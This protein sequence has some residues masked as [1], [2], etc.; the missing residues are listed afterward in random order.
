LKGASIHQ[1]I[2]SREEREGLRGIL[3]DEA[4]TILERE[5]NTPNVKGV[6]L[7]EYALAIVFAEKAEGTKQGELTYIHEQVHAFYH[8]LPND[9]RD[10]YGVACFDWLWRKAPEVYQKIL[11]LYPASKQVR[12]NEACSFFIQELVNRLGIESF[13]TGTPL[14]DDFLCN[15]IT[16]FKKYIRNEQKDRED[17]RVGRGVQDAETSRN[18]ERLY[19]DNLVGRHYGSEEGQDGEREESDR[20]G[21]KGNDRENYGQAQEKLG[22]DVQAD[23]HRRTVDVAQ[24]G[25]LYRTSEQLN[26]EYGDRWLTEQTNNDGRHTTQVRNTISSYEKFGNFVKNDSKGKSVTI[27]DA[28]SGLGHGTE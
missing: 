13:L 18:G 16:E 25:K 22:Q 8:S 9:M 7:P 11:R 1:V 24:G 5:Y 15:F 17:L 10:R 27:L 4:Y 28:S 21:K 3:S 26:D 14:G 19:N 20:R 2:S 6:Y 12:L 23:R